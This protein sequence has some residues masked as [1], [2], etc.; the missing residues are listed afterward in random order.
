MFLRPAVSVTTPAQVAFA[1]STVTVNQSAG[2]AAIEVVRTGG[3]QGPIT[4]NIGTTNGT[5]VAGV[6]YTPISQTLSFAEGQDSQMVMVPINSS[7][8]IS[9]PVTVNIILSGPGTNATLGSLSTATL[10][11][12]TA[13]TPPPLGAGHDAK[14]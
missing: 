1:A 12:Q 13:S 2:Q 4:V 9:T 7:S 14:C 11:I 8:S 6:N 10:V 5:A 3:Y